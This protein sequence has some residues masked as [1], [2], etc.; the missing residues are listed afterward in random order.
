MTVRAKFRVDRIERTMVSVDIDGEW[1][2]QERWT[3]TMFPVYSNDEHAENRK[4]WN[5]TP[6]GKIE[7][8][9]VNADAVAEF[10]LEDEFYVDFIKA[11]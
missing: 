5:A 3:V 2:P 6:A 9:T 4:F 7:L 10:D 1:V 11:G 8:N